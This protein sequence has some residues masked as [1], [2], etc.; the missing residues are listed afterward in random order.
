MRMAATDEA[1][2]AQRVMIESLKTQQEEQTKAGTK[3]E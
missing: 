3:S 1:I 2:A